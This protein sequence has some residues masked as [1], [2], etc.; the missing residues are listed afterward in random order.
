MNNK[1]IIFIA[2]GVSLAIGAAGGFLL[3]SHLMKKKYDD[4]INQMNDE[5]NEYADKA[6]TSSNK[7]IEE[8]TKVKDYSNYISTLNDIEKKLFEQA[9][10][11]EQFIHARE[12]VKKN[13]TLKAQ[14]ITRNKSGERLETPKEYEERIK[15]AMG[16]DPDDNSEFARDLVEAGPDEE[17]TELL[18]YDPEP[19]YM[20]DETDFFDN[21]FENF[22]KIQFTY[23]S[24]GVTV[25]ETDDI[26]AAPEDLVGAD[27]IIEL[28]PHNPTIFVRNEAL[29]TDYEIVYKE[30]TYK[31]F[32]GAD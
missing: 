31:E 29:S 2:S 32:M 18:K 23:F 24:D 25:D 22:E 6:M 30:M 14:Y 1:V 15:T 27:N 28:G 8:T 3:G 12:M 10:D 13:D 20:I 11:K 9:P 17:G 21:Q 19:P 26:I 4:L 5:L 16:I 7:T